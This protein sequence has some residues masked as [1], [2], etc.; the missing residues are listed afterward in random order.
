MTI[1]STIRKAGP[2]IGNGTASSFP[3]SFKVFQASDLDVVRLLVSSGVSSTLTLITDYTVTLNQDQDS[4]PGGTVTLVSGPLATGYT[5][6]MTSDLPNLQPTDLTN[7]GGFYP[8][9]INDALDRSTI[10]IQQLA[11]QVGRSLKFS[12]AESGGDPTL[13]AL[14][15]RQG[16]L[17]AFDATTGNPIAGPS[18]GDASTLVNNMSAIVTV[19]SDLNGADTIGTVASNIA[20]VLAAPANAAIAQDAANYLSTYISQILMNVTFPLDL[21]LVADPVLYNHFDLGAL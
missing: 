1:S 15:Q 19:A 7:Q 11:D 9:V 8:E 5:L 18:L 10:Q 16:K 17:L 6:T 20:A 13:P 4:N 3:F 2:F 14:A 12:F 21:G